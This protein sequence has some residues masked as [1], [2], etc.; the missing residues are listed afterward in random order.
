M[1]ERNRPAIVMILPT[2]DPWLPDDPRAR[3]A[4]L[5]R[6]LAHLERIAQRARRRAADPTATPL[7][8]GGRESTGDGDGDGEIEDAEDTE[9]AETELKP[10]TGRLC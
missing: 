6:Q 2:D 9:D 8:A 4:R 5:D 1:S 7:A 10:R 3:D